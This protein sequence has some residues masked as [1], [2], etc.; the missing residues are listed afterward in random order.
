MRALIA[1]SH[2]LFQFSRAPVPNVSNV[3]INREAE[4]ARAGGAGDESTLRGGG[5]EEEGEE[6][7]GGGGERGR[8]RRKRNFELCNV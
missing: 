8:S 7:G 1:D 3:S 4:V 2:D 5:G 6:G